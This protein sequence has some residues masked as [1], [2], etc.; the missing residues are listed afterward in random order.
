[1]SDNGQSTPA[2]ATAAAV[3]E[4]REIDVFY[5]RV[6]ALRKVSLEVRQGEIVT[7]VG[8]TRRGWAAP[9][10]TARATSGQP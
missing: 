2:A 9:P 4:L 6:S 1:M 7:L 8:V 3:I 5:G 10:G